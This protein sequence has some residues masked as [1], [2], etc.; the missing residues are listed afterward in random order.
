[1]LLKQKEDKI[2]D[3][4][5]LLEQEKSNSSEKMELKMSQFEKDFESLNLQHQVQ[6]TE[7]KTQLAATLNKLQRQPHLEKF[8]KEALDVNAKLKQQK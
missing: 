1:M 6:L 2:Q 5:R 7:K 3:L 8:I 4:E